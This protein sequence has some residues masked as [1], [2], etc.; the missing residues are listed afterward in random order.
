MKKDL[1]FPDLSTS[2]ED[3]LREGARKL[4]QQAIENEVIDFLERHAHKKDENNKRTVKRNGYSPGRD[5]QTGIGPV[6]VKQPRIRGEQF[7]SAILPKYL[8]RLPS[9]EALI[10]A[11]YLKGI[12]TGNMEEALAAILG[13]NQED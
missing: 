13:K 4:L 10:P 12:S 2:L 3:I 8:R 9:I 1:I 5:I 7:T 11:L 6:S